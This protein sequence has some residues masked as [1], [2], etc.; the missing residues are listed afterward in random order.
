LKKEKDEEEKQEIQIIP[1]E[2]TNF[3]DIG[4]VDREGGVK[5]R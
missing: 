3:E 1:I 2:T 4:T 5:L